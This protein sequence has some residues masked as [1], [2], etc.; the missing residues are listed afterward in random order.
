MDAGKIDQVPNFKQK[1]FEGEK[2]D[3]SKVKGQLESEGRG[4]VV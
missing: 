4:G 1:C 3:Y 2:D